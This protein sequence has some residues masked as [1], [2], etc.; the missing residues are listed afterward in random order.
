MTRTIR[1]LILMWMLVC[2]ITAVGAPKAAA[3]APATSPDTATVA[4]PGL[5][6]YYEIRGDGPPLVLLHGFLQTGRMFDPFVDAFAA[7]YRVIIPDLRGHGGS[8]NPSGEFTM[9]QSAQDILALLD[10]LGISRFKA[11]GFSAG[12]MTL[13]HMAT[14]QPDRVEAMVLV[15]A[16]TYF[17][18]DCRE[19]LGG[20]SAEST[21]EAQW[22]ALRALHRH[23]DEQIGALLDQLGGFKDVYGD[24]AFTPPLLAT[25]RA[26]TLLIQG[27]QDRCFPTT[28]IVDMHAAIPGA[29]L[30][31]I[32]NAG[33]WPVA[34][35]L[36]DQF[37]RT[38][39]SFL[40]GEWDRR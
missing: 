39:L 11:L 16:G 38:V 15:G 27:D 34:P 37:T 35:D 22:Q 3:Q 24:V 9:R 18:V 6:M 25:I 19:Y 31:V 8:T 12:S 1:P 14:M 13:L 32:P 5:E 4:L 17:S 33:H 28:M 7:K 23:G 40:G 10:H 2:L 29:R 21:P 36:Q 20:I 30:W 26:R